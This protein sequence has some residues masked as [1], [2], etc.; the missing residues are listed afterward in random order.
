MRD[1][2]LALA[3]WIATAA[4]PL[5]GCGSNDSAGPSGRSDSPAK[6]SAA[7][8]TNRS[9]ALPIDG[10]SQGADGSGSNISMDTQ[11]P[12]LPDQVQALRQQL[13]HQNQRT[14]QRL[15]QQAQRIEH[16]RQ[17]VKQLQTRL[18]QLSSSSPTTKAT[19]RANTTPHSAAHGAKAPSMNASSRTPGAANASK[20]DSSNTTAGQDAGQQK[21]DPVQNAKNAPADDYGH[22]FV[23]AGSKNVPASAHPASSRSSQS[24][25]P[26]PNAPDDACAGHAP[27]ARDDLD[28]VYRAPSTA[29]LHAA[30]SK[31][32]AAGV[33]DWFIARPGHLL[34]LGRYPTCA[35]ARHRRQT[36]KARTDLAL[37]I[38]AAI[39]HRTT[40]TGAA[41]PADS[42]SAPPLTVA[43]FTIVGV[44]M[45]GSHRYLGVSA[46][47]VQQL[48]DITWLS[49]GQSYNA[50]RLQAILDTTATFVVDA[51]KVAVVL[52]AQG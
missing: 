41:G 40:R 4:V 28:V 51:R 1:R 8:D 26:H 13:K 23:G 31:I 18:H 52:P 42:A 50:W 48:G 14:G 12:A 6:A 38:V 27:P 9:S 3:L 20:P 30:L 2:T 16:L 25:G 39:S 19:S 45:R 43:P 5:A 29:A 47:A 36:V 35:R 11:E 49:P 24:S 34:Y 33:H 21:A 15:D 17:T 22:D 32:K 46:G 7:S 44:E 37:S 10:A